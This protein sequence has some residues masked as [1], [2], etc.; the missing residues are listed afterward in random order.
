MKNPYAGGFY[1]LLAMLLIMCVALVWAIWSGGKLSSIPDAFA[2]I[3][4]I[5]ALFQALAAGVVAALA[6]KGLT[7]WKQELLHGKAIAVLWDVNL[8]FSTVEGSIIRLAKRWR[9]LPT[10]KKSE[11][12]E[13]E[14]QQDPIAKQLE[15]FS[16]Q[17]LIL[18]RVVVKKVD[19]WVG[20]AK[21]L[22]ILVS[23]FA[24]EVHKP[25]FDPKDGVLSILTSKS[26]KNVHESAVEIE[27]LI[28]L[29]RVEIQRLEAKY[30]S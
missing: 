14:L 29:I 11:I 28:N 30:S 21:R 8:A 4:S 19:E 5:S 20:R 16:E 26:E 6:Y 7:N 18:D 3:N 9:Y 17:C 22:S 24:V 27:A 23:Q 2:L 25:Q 1:V 10:V 13:Q 15:V 12:V